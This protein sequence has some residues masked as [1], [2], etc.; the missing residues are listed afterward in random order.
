M[1]KGSE[2]R[3]NFSPQWLPLLEVLYMGGQLHNIMEDSLLELPFRGL[4]SPSKPPL[5]LFVDT[6]G[7]EL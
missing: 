7:P 3:L 2:H 1:A 5:G 4:S 6:D